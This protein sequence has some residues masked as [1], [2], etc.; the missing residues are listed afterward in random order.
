MILS[1]QDVLAQFASGGI[2]LTPELDRFQLQ[3]HAIDLRLGYKFLIPRN[4]TIDEKGR[5]AIKVS[6]DDAATHPEQFDEV[7]LKP[8]QYFEL[9]PNEFVIG[10]SLERIEMNAPNLMAI[11]F[12]RTSTNRRGI[13]LSLSGIIDVGYKGNLIFPMQNEAGNQVIRV[14][15]GERVCQVIFE[16][17]K[18]PL[19]PE[20]ADLHGVSAAKYSESDGAFKLDK[21]EERQALITGTLDEMKRRFGI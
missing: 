18:T 1:R 3:P 11:L 17:L 12:P 21:D 4:W 7:I 13:D 10:T 19:T 16:E 20:E 15:P 14:Y 8:G 6:I 9:L 5:R 2:R